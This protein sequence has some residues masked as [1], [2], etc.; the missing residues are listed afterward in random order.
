MKKLVLILL[1]L[2]SGCSS[3]VPQHPKPILYPPIQTPPILYD[4]IQEEINLASKK[5]EII[6]QEDNIKIIDKEADTN[7]SDL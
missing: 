6:L 2:I 4:S 3:I 7:W 5:I 1:L